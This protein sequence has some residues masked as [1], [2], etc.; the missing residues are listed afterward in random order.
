MKPGGLL[1]ASSFEYIGCGN[2]AVANFTPDQLFLAIQRTPQERREARA[3]MKAEKQFEQTT[4]K[5]LRSRPRRR[6]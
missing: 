4:R 5:E 2:L 1:V 3:W 6:R